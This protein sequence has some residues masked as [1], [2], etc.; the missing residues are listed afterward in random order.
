MNIIVGL[1]FLVCAFALVA[2]IANLTW[3]GGKP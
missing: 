3:K 2:V 1:F